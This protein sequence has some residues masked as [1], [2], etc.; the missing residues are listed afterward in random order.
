VRWHRD[1][2][3][4]VFSLLVQDDETH[5]KL[6]TRLVSLADLLEH[7][8]FNL[9]ACSLEGAEGKALKSKL[10]KKG[11]D[12]F[13]DILHSVTCNTIG[14]LSANLPHLVHRLR[15]FFGSALPEAR[16]LLEVCLILGGVAKGLA[17]ATLQTSHTFFRLE[18]T[19]LDVFHLVPSRED[20]QFA[21]T[22]K[23]VGCKA[24][25]CGARL[26]KLGLIP[27]EFASVLEFGCSH[28]HGDMAH[29]HPSSSSSSSSSSSHSAAMHLDRVDGR[30][31]L[32]RILRHLVTALP[33]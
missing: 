30:R 7:G 29:D 10:S 12:D 8:D 15:E 13:G 9:N 18:A 21:S 32:H 20:C 5:S 28:D 31:R 14:D 23:D 11:K 1:L 2:K 3:D 6:S 26:A 25:E 27:D 33:R 16:G 4:K 17:L 24:A 22:D 19:E